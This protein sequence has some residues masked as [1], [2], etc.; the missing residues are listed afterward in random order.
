MNLPP[1]L[2]P[3]VPV[4]PGVTLAMSWRG[5]PAGVPGRAR[6]AR[7]LG[8][9]G[10]EIVRRGGGSGGIPVVAGVERGGDGVGTK[11][12]RGEAVRMEGVLE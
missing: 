1:S 9:A 12:E 5:L 6:S 4:A 11:G 2:K 8:V 3:T 7:V 10:G